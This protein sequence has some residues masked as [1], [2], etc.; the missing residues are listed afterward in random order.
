MFC[1]DR[2]PSLR[3]EARMLCNMRSELR[4]IAELSPDLA[5]LSLAKANSGFWS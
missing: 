3:L 4:T 2:S 1:D 5:K